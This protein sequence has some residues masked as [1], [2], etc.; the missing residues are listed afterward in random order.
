MD[1]L[2]WLFLNP[3]LTRHVPRRTFKLEVRQ[4]G[5]PRVAYLDSSW[6]YSTTKRKGRIEKCNW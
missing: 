5:E 2:T 6:Y 3:S 4:R 1:K